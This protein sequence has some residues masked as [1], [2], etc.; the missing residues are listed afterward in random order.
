M[1][2]LI[3]GAG[4][5]GGFFGTRLVRA[6]RDVSYLV[7]PPR[8]DQLRHG[9]RVYGPGYDETVPVRALTVRELD[10]PYDLILLMVK[11]WSLEAAL[12]DITPAVGPGTTV[13]PLLNG[14]THLDTVNDRFG[15]A[16][17][18]GGIVRVVCTVTP[19]GAVY[20]LKP[21]AGLI[22]GEQDGRTTDRASAVL[23]ELQVP[24]YRVTMAEDV[25]A[26]MWHKWAFIAAGAAMTCLMRG[27]IGSILS[28]PGG[29][30]FVL[31]VIDETE[32]V[33]RA[34][35]YPPSAAAHAASL[36]MFT[37]EGSVFTS[38]LY[39]DVL[40]GHAHEGE[41]LLG[42]YVAVADRLAVD[43]P[44]TRLA[45]MQLRVHDQNGSPSVH[46]PAIAVEG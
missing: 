2:T 25:L 41:H 20:Q 7:H 22:F 38:S 8:A 24:G 18:L 13:L 4:A 11:A 21:K 36:E 42:Q 37:E 35:G 31:D 3:V 15:R 19:E 9:L 32:R 46:R 30:D 5:T 23:R 6:G 10:G 17:V 28:T 34:A 27:S 45:L 14:L 39:R 26:A 40:A 44:L 33:A 16:T 1:R 12:E 29:K 43:V